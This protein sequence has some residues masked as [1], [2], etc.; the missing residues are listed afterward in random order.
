M[1]VYTPFRA[2]PSRREFYDARGGRFSPELDFGVHNTDP[3]N[4]ARQRYQ[5][6]LVAV[7]GDLYA[8]QIYHP[9]RLYVLGNL[10]GP[11]L[12]SMDK[13]L[14]RGRELF[15]DY[16]GEAVGQTLAW[17][18]ARLHA[19]GAETVVTEQETPAAEPKTPDESEEPEAEQQAAESSP[20]PAG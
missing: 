20:E 19:A 6:T 4:P 12:T 1:E 17:F 2:Y 9:E 7:T 16:N 8:K 14:E 11:E 10:L 15:D 13:V 3:T 5:V 18:A